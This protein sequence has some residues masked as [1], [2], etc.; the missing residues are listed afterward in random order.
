MSTD[1]LQRLQRFRAVCGMFYANVEAT[2]YWWWFLAVGISRRLLFVAV[3][4]LSPR[5]SM[6][7]LFLITLL[8]F[9]SLLLHV[10]HQP[11]RISYDNLFETLTLAHALL[12]FQFTLLT[13]SVSEN[14]LASSLVSLS[15]AQLVQQIL[16][17]AGY[18]LLVVIVLFCLPPS[19]R[20]RVYGVIEKCRRPTR[21]EE[22][23]ASPVRRVTEVGLAPVK[24]RGS[25][26]L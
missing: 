17:Y 10:R 26:S 20:A 24:Q 4:A 25:V 11:Y 2:Q 3:L 15:S 16:Q 21:S 6:L 18:G 12:S 9:L 5:Q 1:Q 14:S 7:S 23:D 8:L 13:Y 22:F 19:I